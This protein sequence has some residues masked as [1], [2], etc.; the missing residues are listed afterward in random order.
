MTNTYSFIFNY[1]GLNINMI[2]S[3]SC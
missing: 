1:L 3:I 2:Q